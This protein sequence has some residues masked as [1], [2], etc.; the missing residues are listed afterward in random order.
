MQMRPYNSRGNVDICGATAVLMNWNADCADGPGGVRSRP[1]F[2][3]RIIR[4]GDANLPEMAPTMPAIPDDLVL[5][6]RPKIESTRIPSTSSSSS[7]DLPVKLEDKN[8]RKRAADEVDAK[9]PPT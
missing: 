6:R 5:R 1:E 4:A 7:S 3:Y 2:D 9:T 8:W